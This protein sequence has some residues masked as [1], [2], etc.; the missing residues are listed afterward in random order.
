M[1]FDDKI[2]IFGLIFLT[3]S[4]TY[5]CFDMIRCARGGSFTK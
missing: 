4:F 3:I 5:I 2:M 1:S